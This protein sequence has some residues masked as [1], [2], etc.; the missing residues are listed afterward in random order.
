MTSLQPPR[1]QFNKRWTAEEV[2]AGIDLTGKWSRAASSNRS[3]N[4][5][6]RPQHRHGQLS[7]SPCLSEFGPTAVWFRWRRSARAAARLR[8]PRILPLCCSG[9]LTETRLRP[10]STPRVAR[11]ACPQPWRLRCRRDHRSQK[12]QASLSG[13]TSRIITANA[14][15]ELLPYHSSRYPRRTLPLANLAA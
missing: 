7:F 15:I 14:V 13:C 4:G 1:N 3:R 6:V 12:I 9:W 2:T 10:K 11:A 5:S 8:A